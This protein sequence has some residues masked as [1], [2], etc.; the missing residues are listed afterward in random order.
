MP[1]ECIDHAA[2]LPLTDLWAR[3]DLAAA[4]MCGYPLAMRYPQ[5]RPLAAPVTVLADDDRAELPLG[6][7]G[8]RRQRH[9]T[10][11]PR[12]LG[13]GSAGWRNTR[14]RASTHRA[15]RCSRTAHR[16]RPHLYRESIG[17]LGHPRG[18]L[19]ALAD[20]RIDVTAVDAYWWWLLQRHDAATANAFRAIG[21]TPGA[22]MPPL[23]S[24]AGFSDVVAQ[25]LTAACSA[26]TRI[27][28]DLPSRRARHP[29][30]CRRCARDYALLAHLDRAAHVAGYPL[31][32]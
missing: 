24:A 21:E 15:M 14:T 19:A 23:V 26:C 18:A 30:V 7:A 11:S 3:E 32:A 10:R 13:T 27:A 8:P 16:R 2:P 22:P 4:F 25:R 9:S 12:H 5:V 29:A 6:L 31:P 17:P 28:S 1:I 20:A